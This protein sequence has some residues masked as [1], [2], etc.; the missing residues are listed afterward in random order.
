MCKVIR[1][2]AKPCLGFKI[3]AAGR[4]CGSTE[5]VQAAFKFGYQN[6][7]PT[8]VLIVGMFPKYKDQI[9][10]NAE[11]TRRFAGVTSAAV[12]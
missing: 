12:S 2:V 8:D 3:L 1:Q 11:H 10:E 9:T 4:K 5:S 6:I 7:K